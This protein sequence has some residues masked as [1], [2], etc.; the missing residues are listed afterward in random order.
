MF[1]GSGDNTVRVF[2]SKSGT[3]KRTFSG[4]TGAVNCFVVSLN[5]QKKKV[6]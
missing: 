5:K 4:H 3:C 6:S 1:T 2:E